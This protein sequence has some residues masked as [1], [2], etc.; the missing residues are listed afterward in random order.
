MLLRLSMFSHS[1]FSPPCLLS[2]KPLIN[3]ASTSDG[4]TDVCHTT[5][6]PSLIAPTRPVLRP[7]D[8]HPQAVIR[9]NRGE[10]CRSSIEPSRLEVASVSLVP[11]RLRLGLMARGPWKRLLAMLRTTRRAI[12]CK[13]QQIRLLVAHLPAHSSISTQDFT[14][15]VR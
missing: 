6:E 12:E 5:E 11:R 2:Y 14:R 3:F 8:R 4:E 7:D 1:G 10:D 9:T 13:S 15:P